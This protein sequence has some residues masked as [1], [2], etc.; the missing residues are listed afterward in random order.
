MSYNKL[1]NA[2]RSEFL[3]FFSLSRF[4]WAGYMNERA[5]PDRVKHRIRNSESLPSS[6]CD[7]TVH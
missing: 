7:N 1:A 5:D 3:T 2:I 4:N 6:I